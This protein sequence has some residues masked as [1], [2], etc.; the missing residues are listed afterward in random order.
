MFTITPESIS[1]V[2]IVIG[3][4]WMAKATGLPKRLAPALSLALGIGMTALLVPDPLTVIVQGTF[5]AATASGLYSG[6]K[7][8]LQ[9]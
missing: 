4:V 1:I 7:A 8:T 6:T 2:P 5:I 9:K 3:L